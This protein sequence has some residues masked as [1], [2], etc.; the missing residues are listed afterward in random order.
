MKVQ[1]RDCNR[2]LKLKD[3][4]S[5]AYN[6]R[7]YAYYCMHEYDKALIDL[8]RA[9]ELKPDLSYARFNRS[10][11]RQDVLDN[12]QGAI[13]DCDQLLVYHPKHTPAY[14]RLL[15]LYIED[16][17]IEMARSVIIK[18]NTNNVPKVSVHYLKAYLL[19]QTDDLASAMG[20]LDRMIELAPTNIEAHFGRASIF[21]RALDFKKAIQAFTQCVELMPTH[22]ISYV[23]R[24]LMYHRLQDYELAIAD[25]TKA[26]DLN[27]YLALTYN[28]RAWTL[29]HMGQ[30]DVALRD[31]DHAI[32]L[33]PYM[34]NIYDTRAH[35]YFMMEQYDKA[36]I[37]F[38][39]TTAYSTDKSYGLIGQAVTYFAIGERE[40]AIALWKQAIQKKEKYR[41]PQTFQNDFFPSDEFMDKLRELSKS[42]AT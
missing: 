4:E 12:R 41:D 22:P 17:N 3:K 20:E 11:L 29:G 25:Y 6:N 2:I 19:Q 36:I 15:T 21:M 34:G 9:L 13:E 27:P 38:E 40:Q 14:E 30:Y 31:I 32:E 37:D 24:G 8:D 23:N 35:I 18:A 16:E 33:D 1:S 5:S 42:V 7:G 26:L 28:N 39:Q 10:I